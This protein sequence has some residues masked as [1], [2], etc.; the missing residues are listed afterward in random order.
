MKNVL[1]LILIGLL[2]A[3]TAPETATRVL[4]SNGY[5]NISI[6]GYSWFSC[7]ED[8]TFST[9]FEAV[10]PTGNSV[11]GTVCSGLF[12]GATLRFE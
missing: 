5:K 10:G 12:K 2:S 7:G 8:D 9:G 3:C 6:T 4:E 1:M 11:K